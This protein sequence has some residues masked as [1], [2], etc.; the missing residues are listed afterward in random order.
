[1]ILPFQLKDNPQVYNLKNFSI[2]ISKLKIIFG[3]IKV[4]LSS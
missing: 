4:F 2:E 1:M 3:H